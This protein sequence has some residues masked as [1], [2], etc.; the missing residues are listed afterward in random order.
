MHQRRKVSN[1]KHWPIMS[2]ETTLEKRLNSL[3]TYS[4]LG[5]KDHHAD[6]CLEYAI[7]IIE[8]K[9]IGDESISEYL[10]QIFNLKPSDHLLN[11]IDKLFVK[12]NQEIKTS[13]NFQ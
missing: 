13:E 7:T 1:T 6:E 12:W 8:M 3:L 9:A 5:S 11:E 4:F 10:Q 2:G